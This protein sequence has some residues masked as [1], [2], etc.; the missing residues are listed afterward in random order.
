MFKN[1]IFNTAYLKKII[2]KLDINSIIDYDNKIKI[3]KQWKKSIDDGTISKFNEKQLQG[4]FFTR[5]FSDILEYKDLGYD[6]INLIQE[7][8]T[9][10][11]SSKP[12]AVLGYFNNGKENDVKVIVELKAPNT[13]LDEK[14]K[15]QNDNRTPVDQAFSYAPKYGG[16]CKW[17]IVSNFNEIRLYDSLNQLECE[18][19]YITNLDEEKEFLRFYY[20]LN[21]NNLIAQIE[22]SVIDDLYYRRLE[23][24]EEITKEFYSIY[25]DIRIKII[26]D[27][28]IN[29]HISKELAIEK[30]QKILDRIIFICF[31]KDSQEQLLPRNILDRV[32]NPNQPTLSRGLWEDLKIIFEAIDQGNKKNDINRYNGGL[33]KSDPDLDDLIISDIVLEE[34]RKII[35]YDFNS[36]LDVDILGHILEQSISDIEI[37]KG[38]YSDENIN[39]KEN[40]IYYTPREVTEFMV[41]KS[42]GKWLEDKKIELG[43]NSLPSLTDDEKLKSLTLIK[44]NYKPGKRNSKSSIIYKKYTEIIS[45]WERYREAL[46]KIKVIDIS[47][48]SGAFLNRVLVYLK[49][50]GEKVNKTI[51]KLRNGQEKFFAIDDSVFLELDKGILSNNIYGVDCNKESVEITKLSLWLQ[52]ANKN[53]PLVSLDSNIH[54]GN[55][56]VNDES[57]TGQAA[58]KWEAEFREIMDSGGFDIVIGNPPY[59]DSTRMKKTQ[60]SIRDYCKKNYKT[61][62][63]NWDMYIPFIE[64][65]ISLLKNNGIIAY[66]VPNKIIA[67]PYAESIRNKLSSMSILCL[68]DYSGIKL[69]SDANVYTIV[70]IAQN[71][72]VKDNVEVETYDNKTSYW[73][74]NIIK[75]SEF[76]SDTNWGRY[77]NKD[78]KV[79]KIINKIMDN[80]KLSSY[81]EV[82]EASTVGE[83]YEIKKY[84]VEDN[85]N[86]DLEYSKKFINTGTIDPYIS[87]WDRTITAY[88][89]SKYF[90]PIIYTKD[91]KNISVNRLIQSNKEKIIIGGMGKKLECYYDR[92]EYLAGKSTIIIFDSRINLKYIIAILNSELMEY[93]FQGFYNSLSLC[94]KYINIGA[95][96]I[97]DIP[98]V[99]D[100][101]KEAYIINKVNELIKYKFT[102][103]EEKANSIKKEINHIVYRLYNINQDEVRTLKNNWK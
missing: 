7:T 59:I 23:K 78:K 98:I 83:A 3:I 49:N 43:F 55:S 21:K 101:Q 39:R 28:I 40:G 63:G 35:K 19:F 44:N 36:D 34:L 67:A 32:F 51:R 13:N 71:T 60:S 26:D 58:F 50:E 16:S 9:K 92:G 68:K 85:N 53:K 82:N 102:M 10:V 88:L 41:S 84:L 14:Q 95:R 94:N 6:E 100:E 89:K 17:V 97:K 2:D 62:K 8:S 65:G 22:T 1:N 25:K 12:D 5:I 45:F 4:P 96:Q 47:C 64:R 75:K 15:R 48:G 11:D 72:N 29:N 77:F 54:Y 91:L 74:K 20:I 18:R 66:I 86:F 61:A 42:I 103:D 81:A 31:C 38:S 46:Y 87:L 24:E 27:I 93:Y 76:Y 57:I 99:Y 70:F 69:F 30:A 80:P 37:L 90:R 56:I 73:N 52:T 79:I 33:F